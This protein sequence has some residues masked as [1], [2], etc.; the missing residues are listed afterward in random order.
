M[1]LFEGL[2]RVATSPIEVAVR[3]AAGVLDFR[4][5]NDDVFGL[6]IATLGAT[7]V[8]RNGASAI[9]YTADGIVE[10]IQK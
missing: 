2:I 3:T 7:R 5:L 9:K 4:D 10:N 1:G 8:I 6:D